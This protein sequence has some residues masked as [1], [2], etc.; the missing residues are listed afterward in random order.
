MD[1]DRGGSFDIINIFVKLCAHFLF[2]LL[3]CCINFVDVG[4]DQFVEADFII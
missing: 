2:I 1:V 3:N 4:S